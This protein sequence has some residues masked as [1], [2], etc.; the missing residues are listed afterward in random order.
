M[1]AHAT[2]VAV[3][4]AGLLIR[5]PSGSGKSGLALQMLALGADLVSDDRTIIRRPDEG[6]PC[7]SAPDAIKGLIEARGLG[8]IPVQCVGPTR[9]AGVLEISIIEE[10]RMP[11]VRT[12]EVL[13]FTLPLLHRVE[14]PW[15]P[16]ALVVWLRSRQGG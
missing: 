4:G 7:A 5:G 1:I 3:G 2:T 16:A 6:A 10:A 13:G 11:P 8:L 12:A 14:A 9:L 15:F